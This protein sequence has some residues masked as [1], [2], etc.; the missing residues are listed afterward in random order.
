MVKIII[1]ILMIF[2]FSGMVSAMSLDVYEPANNGTM[3]PANAYSFGSGTYI[4]SSLYSSL[5]TQSA[6]FIPDRLYAVL[7]P[8]SQFYSTYGS[9]P[10]TVFDTCASN[11]DLLQVVSAQHFGL[12][13]PYSSPDAVGILRVSPSESLGL[14]SVSSNLNGF[15]PYCEGYRNSGSGNM[16]SSRGFISLLPPGKIAGTPGNPGP[17]IYVSPQPTAPVGITVL[18]GQNAN[19]FGVVEVLQGSLNLIYT[20]TPTCFP[21]GLCTTGWTNQWNH[22]YILIACLSNNVCNS[23][24]ARHV[25]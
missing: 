2:I 15:T 14:M 20:S 12:T 8:T 25:S 10:I 7:H 19:W 24:A 1:A 3:S 18:A 6:L 16:I 23:L 22:D 5:S 9:S 21:T 4:F 13:N 11:G 17:Q